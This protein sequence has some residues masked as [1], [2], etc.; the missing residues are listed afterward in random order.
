MSGEGDT[1]VVQLQ[2]D[3]LAVNWKKSDPDEVYPRFA[4]L[5]EFFIESWRRLTAIAKE[6]AYCEPQPTICQVLYVN[7][8]GAAQGWKRVDDTPQVLAPWSGS[9]SDDFLPAPDVAATYQHFHLP[10][11]GRWLDI[12]TGPRKTDDDVCVLAVHLTCRGAAPTPDLEGA[13]NVMD[14]AHDWIVRGFASVTT[15]DAH[16]IW[17]R[18]T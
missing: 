7:H 14:L 12:E 8:I 6:R 17:E 15:S 11:P 5:R 16:A 13:L 18:T 10:E 1:R 2:P 4:N 3:R 9:M